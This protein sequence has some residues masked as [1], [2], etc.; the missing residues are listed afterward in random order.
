MMA[1]LDDSGGLEGG[2]RVVLVALSLFSDCSELEVAAV[3]EILIDDS[4]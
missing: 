1:V 3:P 2:V 4:R